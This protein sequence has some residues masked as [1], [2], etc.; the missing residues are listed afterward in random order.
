MA[1]LPPTNVSPIILN[2]L[3]PPPPPAALTKDEFH[4]FTYLERAENTLEC[5]VD[6]LAGHILRMLNFDDVVH[7]RSL[8][9]K[10]KLSFTI[11]GEIVYA[12]PNYAVMNDNNYALLVQEDRVSYLAI[13]SVMP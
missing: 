1:Q 8:A 4:F 9:L 12:M 7:R 10:K 6:D 2:N 13:F 11:C 5:C 3:R